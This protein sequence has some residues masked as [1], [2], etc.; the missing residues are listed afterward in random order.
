MLKKYDLC[1]VKK[2]IKVKVVWQCLKYLIL[3]YLCYL[4]LYIIF[5]AILLECLNSLC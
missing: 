1:S 2:C 3:K 4:E 5:F